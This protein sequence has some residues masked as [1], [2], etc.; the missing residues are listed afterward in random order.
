MKR[1][2]LILMVLLPAA[3]ALTTGCASLKSGGGKAGI[4]LAYKME[5]GKSFTLKTEGSNLITT[6][7]MGQTVEVETISANETRYTILARSAEGN[8][9]IELEFKNLSQTVKSPMGENKTDYSSWIGKK[10]RFSLSPVG[11]PSG[12]SG[13]DQLPEISTATGEK[14]SGKIMELSMGEIFMNVPDHPLKIGETWTINKTRDIPY[15][16]NTLKNEETIVCTLAGRE[17]VNGLECARITTAGTEKL[18]G[19]LE[20]Q[21]MELELTRETKSTGTLLFA[22]DKGM[23]VLVDGTSTA[24]GDI[25]V[26]SMGVTVNQSIAGKMKVETVFD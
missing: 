17:K 26:S 21:G 18:S 20:Q 12:Y 8:T 13:F 16:S 25:Y 5:P 14:L 15:G 11:E 24:T 1:N 3:L 10:V 6:D 2:Y 19:K 9:D 22:I 23:Y 7:Q 4:V